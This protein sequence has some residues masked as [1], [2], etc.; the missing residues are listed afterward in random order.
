[1]LTHTH[2]QQAHCLHTHTHNKHTLVRR[3]SEELH[4]ATRVGLINARPWIA[5][6]CGAGG[7]EEGILRLD[8]DSHEVG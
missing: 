6:C 5:A 2:T 1:M 7:G 4:G 8:E 3:A